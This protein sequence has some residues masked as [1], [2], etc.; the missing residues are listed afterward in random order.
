LEVAAFRSGGIC[1]RR[2]L[3]ATVLLCGVDVQE[4]PMM[5]IHEEKEKD[6]EELAGPRG[7]I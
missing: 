3:E 2:H 5:L 1:K 7:C 6:L 4:M